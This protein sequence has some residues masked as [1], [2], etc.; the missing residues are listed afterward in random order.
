MV[1]H[2]ATKFFTPHKTT[3]PH[4]LVDHPKVEVVFN[5]TS[6]ESHASL[7]R[8]SLKAGKNVFI[9]K[10]VTLSLPSWETIIGA[11]NIAPN[12]ARAFV[13][14]IIYAPVRD[15]GTSFVDKT[16]TFPVRNFEHPAS[17]SAERN[18]RLDSSTRKRFLAKRPK[19]SNESS[20]GFW[21]A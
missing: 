10:P 12:G 15:L 7:A 17:A 19:L 16:G 1:D 2:Y 20:V 4:E 21:V 14:H 3:N 18:S 6:D 9:E 13:G 11:E 8:A 5:L